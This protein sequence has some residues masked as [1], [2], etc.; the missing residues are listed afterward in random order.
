MRPLRPPRPPDPPDPTQRTERQAVEAHDINAS[1]TPTP[2]VAEEQDVD[3]WYTA[4]VFKLRQ[5]FTSEAR[6]LEEQTRELNRMYHLATCEYPLHADSAIRAMTDD[7]KALME[8][9]LGRRL[10]LPAPPNF[11]SCTATAYKRAALLSFHQTH[12]E[13]ALVADVPA[14]VRLGKGIPRQSVLRELA[15]N[16]TTTADAKTRMKAFLKAAQRVIFDG[17]HTLTFTFISKRV[18]DSWVHETFKLRGCDMTLLMVGVERAGICPPPLLARNYAIRVMVD[19]ELDTLQLI[20][21]FADITDGLVADV[22]HPGE[23][24][25]QQLDNNYWIIVF[26]TRSCPVQLAGITSIAFGKKMVLL[27]HFQKT[28]TAPCTR[29]YNSAHARSRCTVKGNRLGEVRSHR[30]REYIG[31]YEAPTLTAL[32]DCINLSELE[33]HLMALTFPESIAGC[34]N[35]TR[36]P[37]LR[38]MVP[39]ATA[40]NAQVMET[41]PAVSSMTVTRAIR[42]SRKGGRL[43]DRERNTRT[44]DRTVAAGTSHPQLSA[45]QDNSRV[46]HGRTIG[47]EVARGEAGP[48]PRARTTTTRDEK[49]KKHRVPSQKHE[50]L[51]GKSD[52]SDSEDSEP[53]VE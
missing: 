34:G 48:T 23:T 39:P 4:A 35:V 27:H 10:E 43:G 20:Q 40:A 24:G 12:I 45:A 33:T 30:Q 53:E 47:A 25:L 16:N 38:K 31:K 46:Q 52:K 29:C 42:S 8:A 17:E 44:A 19:E 50:E 6:A 32:P 11:L 18:A 14:L 22:R 49:K 9:Y 26:S 3:V 36:A 13:A 41:A 1:I 28:Q 15:A 37:V 21:M 7:E 2:N 51:M 5:E